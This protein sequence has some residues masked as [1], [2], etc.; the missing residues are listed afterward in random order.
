MF[1][2]PKCAHLKCATLIAEFR[3]DSYFIEN[4]LK[5]SYLNVVWLGS[6]FIQT[7]EELAEIYKIEYPDGLRRFIVL[8][9]TPSEAIDAEVKFTQ[10]TLPRCEEYK[11]LQNSHCRYDLTP[12]RKYYAKSLDADSRLMYALREFYITDPDLESFQ[13]E[14]RYLRNK[15]DSIYQIYNKVACNWIKRN[16]NE[17]TKW[18]QKQETVKT[19]VIGGIFPMFFKDRGHF[20]IAEA[21]EKAVKAINA[22]TTILPDYTLILWKNDDGNC[23]SDTV[24]KAFIHYYNK[25]NVLGVLG[26]ACSE[27]VESIA[28]LSKTLKMMTIS[29]SADGGS[30]V[31][32]NIYPYLFRTIGSKSQYVNAYMEIMHRLGWNRASTLTEDNQQYTEYVSHME[33]RLKRNNFTLAF[34]RKFEANVSAEDMNEVSALLILINF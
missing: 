10:I 24:M 29:Y 16:K 20:N 12:I 27:T 3:N 9:W 21:A 30:F 22:N 28:G 2:N 26:P 6:K 5:E 33:S 7:V 14:L 18:I 32:R 13:K 11:Y 34:N 1:G 15:N 31:D 8:H 23:E 17:Y 19:L 4:E 25:S